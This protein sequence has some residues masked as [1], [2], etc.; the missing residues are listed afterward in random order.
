MQWQEIL[1]CAQ[2]D[3]MGTISASTKLDSLL[4]AE[5]IQKSNTNSSRNWHG[6]AH[7]EQCFCTVGES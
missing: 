5:A 3:W 7:A 4:F 6:R 2:A 1:A